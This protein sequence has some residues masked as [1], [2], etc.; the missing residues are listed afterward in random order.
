MDI[1]LVPGMWLDGSAWADVAE[2][3]AEAGHRPLALTLPGME[4]VEADRSGI[5]LGD[6][7]D[8]V[9]AAI[10]AVGEGADE[11]PKV[12]LVGHSAAAG[13]AWSAVDARPGRVARAV[14]VSGFP[15]GDGEALAAGYPA[16]RGEV[17][18]P[19]WSAFGD[20]DLA[21]LDDDG[22]A[23]LRARA[24]PFPEHVVTDPQRLTDERRYSVPVTAVATEYTTSDLRAAIVDGPDPEFA[25]IEH[26]EYVDLPTGHW[27]MLT[28][29]REL[30][31]IIETAARR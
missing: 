4:S 5:R 7:V 6:H 12:L 31:G 13:I 21:D 3:L 23:A 17:P 26:V 19:D 30:A 22:R 18:F 10:D 25:A 1:I 27:P 29:P 15:G 8:A 24:I 11:P 16:D 28:R 2:V 9:V 14:L 20:E